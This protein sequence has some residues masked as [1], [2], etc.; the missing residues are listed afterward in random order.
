MLTK[1]PK[2]KSKKIRDSAKDELCTLRVTNCSGR[3]TVVFC[4]LNTRF[5]GI[6]N[7]SLDIHGVYGC[8]NCH[9]KLDSAKVSKADQLRALVETQVKLIQ[10]GL[11]EVK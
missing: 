1:T 7:K 9:E 2:I 8:Y 5:K 3:E 10:K 6:G 11:I 4:H